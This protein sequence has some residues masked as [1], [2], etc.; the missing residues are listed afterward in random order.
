M[1]VGDDGAFD[2]ELTKIQ[3]FS[4]AKNPEEIYDWY[5][6]GPNDTLNSLFSCFPNMSISCKKN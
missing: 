2:G 5:L 3:L 6:Q 4:K 1:V